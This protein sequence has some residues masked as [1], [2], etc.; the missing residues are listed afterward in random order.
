MP[1]IS[2]F[3]GPA[4]RAIDDWYAAGDVGANLADARNFL[5]SGAPFEEIIRQLVAA[6]RSRPEFQYPLTAVQGTQFE[7]VARQ[8]YLEAIGL[9]LRHTPPV[10]IGTLWMTGAGNTQFEAHA[11]DG[12]QQVSVTLVVPEV[13]GDSFTA[14]SPESW[15]VELDAAGALL[16]TQTSGPPGATPPSA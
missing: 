11:T 12:L 5:A 4:A 2:L 14:G 10:P 16:V 15:A 1:T 3:Q 6:R 9:A 8:A 7:A 13:A